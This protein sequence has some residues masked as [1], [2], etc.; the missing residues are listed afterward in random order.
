LKVGLGAATAAP[1][2]HW[3]HISL[4]D[5]AKGEVMTDKLNEALLCGRSGRGRQTR[6]TKH[7]TLLGQ[8][9]P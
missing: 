6:L 1:S 9:V 4:Q 3:R 5:A 7:C 2:T 8:P